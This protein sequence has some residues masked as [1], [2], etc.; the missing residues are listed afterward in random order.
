[1]PIWSERLSTPPG[2]GR[3]G[4]RGSN[5]RAAILGILLAWPAIAGEKA[6]GIGRPLLVIISLDGVRHDYPDRISGGGFSRLIQEGT[7]ADRLLPAFPA[8][9]FPAHVTLATGCFA[10]RHGILNSRFL[11]VRRGEFDR[12]KEPDW[13]GCE[14]LWITAERQG[15]RT[16]VL[17]WTGSFGFWG[18]REATFHD[19]EFTSRTDREA[20]D[21]ILRWTGRPPDSRPRLILAYFAG[22]DHPGHR[23]GPDSPEVGTSIRRLDGMLR[24]LE[25]EL[26]RASPM[27]ANLIVVSDHGM[28]LRK[29]QLD[30][31]AVL[32]GHGIG[33][34]TF[35]SGGSANVYLR[36]IRALPGAIRILSELPGLR[37]FPQEGIPA[38][39]HYRYPGRT[40]DIVL[41]APVGVELVADGSRPSSDQGVH[42]YLGSE[43]SMG[44]VFF[45]WGPSFRRGLRVS[46]IRAVDLY[47]L[48]CALLGIQVSPQNQGKLRSDLLNPR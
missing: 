46:Q 44:G 42:G 41:L 36:T 38:E 14:P 17:N 34:R 21:Q 26:E 12:S 2:G 27:P 30:P 7:S 47:P 32:A 40:G 23:N 22:A 48:A 29:G 4:K 11:D 35:C 45:G 43:E 31:G 24:E 5:A 15:V 6:A 19:R 25:R 8:S 13:I 33:N 10:E 39:F 16:A 18:G 9:T 3:S 20:L 37:V 28:A 1:M